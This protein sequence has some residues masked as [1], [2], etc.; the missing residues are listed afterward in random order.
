[1]SWSNAAIG[2]VVRVVRS[3]VTPEEI[4]SGTR[5]VGLEHINGSGEFIDVGLVEAGQLASSKFRFTREHVL[6]GK[7]RPYLKKTARPYFEGVCSTDI[8]P[9]E[10]TSRID[11]DYL[12]HVLRRQSFV[13]EVSSLCTG[14]NLPRISPKVLAGV[15]IP[16]PPIAEQ[17]RIAAILD[18]A[19]A[20]RAKRREAITKLDQ[21]LQSVFVDM[22]GDPV[23]SPRAAVV[24]LS[25]ICAK[26][27][28]GTH[29]SPEWT[30]IGVPFLF[31]SNVKPGDINFDTKKYISLSEHTALT[32]RNPIEY[33]DV[34]YT[35]VGSYGNAAMVRTRGKFCFQ[36]HIAQLKPNAGVL[37]EYLE[38]MMNQPSV[39]RQADERV[40]GIAQKTLIL[41][42]LRGLK[43]LSPS[44][45]EQKKFCAI[46][47]HLR[48]VKDRVRDQSLVL[49][50]MFA[51]LQ[52]SAFGGKV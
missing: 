29:Q 42:E 49:E 52:Y 33:G 31:Q 15:K 4:E 6:F 35:I 18:K 38:A 1:M 28:D 47:D 27:T 43:V 45:D 21:L 8:L 36:R 50:T 7:L 12:F 39:K 26:I 30:S 9:L 20:L 24:P 2:D 22:F 16:V 48:R 41:K 14:A 25:E 13:D 10:P 32:A 34:L 40:T 23:V 51:S 46:S 11:R 3:S 17:R 5:Y 19:D 44:I 37:P